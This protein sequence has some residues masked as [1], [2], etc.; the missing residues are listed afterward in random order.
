MHRGSAGP[1]R[2]RGTS[3]AG[4]AI[5]GLVGGALRPR[6]LLLVGLLALAPSLAGAWLIP[7]GA[8]T[9]DPS[10]APDEGAH[11]DYAAALAEGRWQP[12]PESRMA[13]FPPSEYALQAA[14]LALA[15][16]GADPA[17]A[18][19][20]PLR[21]PC[22]RGFPLARVASVLYGGAAVVALAAAAAA[23]TG[24]RAQGVG[25][26]LVAALHPQRF[27]VSSH[28]N[29]EAPA[30]AAGAL[31]VLALARWSSRG[32]G[33]RGLTAVGAASGLVAINKLTGFAALPPTA[34]WIGWAVARGRA[35]PVAAARAAA[36]AL[37]LAAP[38][39]AWN[40]V[41]NGGDPLG[42]AAIRRFLESPAWHGAG[43]LVLPEH[44][45]WVFF[46]T[47]ARSSFMKFS[48]MSL[49]LPLPLYL[50]W[51]LLVPLG[52]GSAVL[53]LGRSSGVARRSAGWVGATAV[54]SLAACLWHSFRYDFSP[55]GRYVLLPVVLLTV[56]AAL[57]PPPRPA[58][59]CRAWRPA[60]LA[61]FAI[62][63]MASLWL[64]WAWPCGPGVRLPEGP[65]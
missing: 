3:T 16:A 25:A 33:E 62:A 6:D 43:G 60:V 32:E 41:R 38:V 4:G 54:L 59:L 55:Q 50:P 51:L 61:F 9:P 65:P 17:W 11:M 30:L 28:V 45:L 10:C 7:L 35:R 26:G 57:S 37:A 19:R 2:G 13:M 20:L 46:R 64:L 22:Y 34:L 48:N 49:A 52:L 53:S 14:A 1:A 58:W 29:A 21:A 27:F 12:W 15:R 31:L 56:A 8:G 40:A 39:L 44:A 42:L 24:S 5:A 63:A 47:L 18:Y 36:A 23:A